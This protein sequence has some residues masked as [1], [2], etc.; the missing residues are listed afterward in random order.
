MRLYA[1]YYLNKRILALMVGSF[2]LASAAA[3]TVMGI[4]LQQLTAEFVD[5]PSLRTPFCVPFVHVPYFYAY[6]IPSLTF[7]S[8][9]CMLALVRGF[10][11]YRERGYPFQSGQNLVVILIRDS[12]CYY[13][14]M[15]ATY[16]TCLLVWVVNIDLLEIPIVFTIAFSC[17][18]G[19]RVILNVKRAKQEIDESR[20]N[21][22]AANERG[23]TKSSESDS[24]SH[25]P[26]QESD[27]L[28]DFEMVQ[29]RTMRADTIDIEAILV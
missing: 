28:T 16:L 9:L 21:A 7:E 27:T 24:D 23:G 19:N 29:L 10:Q 6:W 5:L 17:V 12:V 15:F 8:L 14:V 11:V 1:L 20:A 2:L 3:A 13:T 18:L 26:R 22:D 25:V 4:V